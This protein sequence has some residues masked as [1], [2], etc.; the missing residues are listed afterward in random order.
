MPK[1]L[2]KWY[3]DD[4]YIY[5]Y[6]CMMNSGGGYVVHTYLF[7]N[8]PIVLFYHFLCMTRSEDIL[9]VEWVAI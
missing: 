7:I 6:T 2:T 5:G 8:Q 1:N 3:M 4:P 9:R